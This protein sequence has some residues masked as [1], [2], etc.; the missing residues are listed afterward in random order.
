MTI[1][2]LEGR[3]FRSRIEDVAGDCLVLARPLNLPVE[4][5]FGIGETVLLSWPDP[6]GITSATTELIESTLRGP[7]GLW[8]VRVIGDYR[9][10]QRR[11]F[12]RVPLAGPVRLVP[13]VGEGEAA[14]SA[15]PAGPACLAGSVPVAGQ[16]LDIS[17]AAL[18]CAVRAD[19]VG[20]LTIEAEALVDFTLAHQDFSFTATV[21]KLQ[22]DRRDQEAIEV[23]LVFEIGEEQAA[24]LRRAVFAEQLRIRNG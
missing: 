5:E 18:R 13:V 17:E 11:R 24:L 19:A 10:E 4:H 21:M 15:G 1:A 22:P 20:G 3:A 9:R 16:L 6:G 12:V 23:V 14:G 2:D 8:T 7:L